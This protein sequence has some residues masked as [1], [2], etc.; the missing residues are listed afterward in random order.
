MLR[1]VSFRLVPFHAVSTDAVPR[2]KRQQGRRK[3]RAKRRISASGHA[4]EKWAGG[5]RPSPVLMATPEAITIFEAS[6]RPL[7]TWPS[8]NETKRNGKRRFLKI[9]RAGAV[10]FRRNSLK[11]NA[12]V[13]NDIGNVF[14]T[15]TVYRFLYIRYHILHVHVYF[16]IVAGLCT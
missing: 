11:P 2:R 1:F 15:C 6:A 16:Y 12:I 13:L 8:W 14:L 7:A 4:R 9:V 3:S 5:G 10:P